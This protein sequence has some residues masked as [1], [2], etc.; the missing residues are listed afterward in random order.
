VPLLQEYLNI[1]DPK[2]AKELHAFHA[3]VFRKVPSPLLTGLPKLRE[4]LAKTYPSANELKEGEIA[5]ASFTDELERN[6][7]IDRL[8]A[9]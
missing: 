2:A 5:D 3:S 1:D 7:F 8:Y 4:F 6:G 9:A